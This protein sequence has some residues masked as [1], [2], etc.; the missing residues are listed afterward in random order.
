M[1]KLF[2]LALVLGFCS[3]VSRPAPA[4]AYTCQEI[5]LGEYNS[6]QMD[7]RFSPYPGCYNDCD[8]W[9]YACLAGC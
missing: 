8:Q 1:K 3:V 5:C 2:G 9:Y 4:H 6:C 7:C